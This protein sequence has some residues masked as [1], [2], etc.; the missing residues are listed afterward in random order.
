MS[1]ED[2][3]KVAYPKRPFGIKQYRKLMEEKRKIRR[4]LVNKYHGD[5][6]KYGSVTPENK[7]FMVNEKK[8][9]QEQ[10]IALKEINEKLKEL[11]RKAKEYYANVEG[12][13]E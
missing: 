10:D 7:E 11:D 2:V 3:L 12:G 9:R 8:R 6:S 13:K 1:W 5:Y 4:E